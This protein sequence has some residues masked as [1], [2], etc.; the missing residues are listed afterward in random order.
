VLLTIVGAGGIAA[1]N[2]WSEHEWSIRSKAAALEARIAGQHASRVAS[3]AAARAH[4]AASRVG[5]TMSGSALT[6]KIKSKMVLDDHVKARGINVDTAGT[7]VTLSGTVRSVE[8]RDRALWLAQDT[9][10]VTHVVDRL[11][12][13]SRG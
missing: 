2:Y 6:A 5:G 7:I 9:E 11:H 10:G 8:E 1:F 12:V 13:D 4:D 3:R